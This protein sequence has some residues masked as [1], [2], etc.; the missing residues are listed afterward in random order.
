MATAVIACAALRLGTAGLRELTGA[1]GWEDAAGVIGLDL[2]AA[3]LYAA[4]AFALEDTRHRPVLPVGRPGNR[5]E[6]V[7]RGTEPGE[8]PEL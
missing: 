6:A 2:T 3:A 4:A 1:P 5:S 8:R 7:R